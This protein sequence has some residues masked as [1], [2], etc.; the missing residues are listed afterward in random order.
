MILFLPMA[1]MLKVVCEE[2]EQLKPIALLI[3]DTNYNKKPV[4][5]SGKW[6][7]KIK[8]FFKKK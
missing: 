1:A 8:G 4:N 7:E 2:Y 6:I 5:V 3:S